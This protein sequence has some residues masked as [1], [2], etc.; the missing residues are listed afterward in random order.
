MT[1]S[2]GSPCNA[3]SASFHIGVTA[4]RE[5]RAS[6]HTAQRAGGGLVN[7]HGE[8]IR[9]G[10]SL[11]Y[12]KT[13]AESSYFH[14]QRFILEN[15]FCLS[16]RV[17]LKS[18]VILFRVLLRKCCFKKMH[19]IPHHQQGN[20]GKLSVCAPRARHG[21][22]LLIARVTP[23]HPQNNSLGCFHM[24]ATLNP[25]ATQGFTFIFLLNDSLL[26]SIF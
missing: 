18:N 17:Y 20:S 15:T 6:S 16:N 14:L 7:A 21:A 8:V 24:S 13:L 23:L 26:D 10:Y 11:R 22:V 3:G 12:I 25:V 4:V 5:R 2:Y 9:A 1:A 19:V